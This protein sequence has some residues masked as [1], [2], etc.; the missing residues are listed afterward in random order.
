MTAV[1]GQPSTNP[2]TAFGMYD[3]S[4]VPMPPSFGRNYCRGSNFNW[5]SAPSWSDVQAL[6]AINDFDNFASMLEGAAHTYYHDPA[7]SGNCAVGGFDEAPYDPT[8]FMHHAF[9]DRV[10]CMWR[11]QHPAN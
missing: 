9:V 3:T 7:G 2:T 6:I 1:M 11:A 10:F 8:F 4:A 5:N